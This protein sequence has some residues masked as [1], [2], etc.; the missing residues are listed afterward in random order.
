MI[1][2]TYF[3]H[4]TTSDNEQ[5]FSTGW[6]E[7]ELSEIGNRQVLELR[8]LT[9]HMN[10]D[11]V[12]CSDLGRAVDT[13]NIVFSAKNQIIQDC[14][15][16][17]ANYGDLNQKHKDEFNPDPYWYIHNYFPNGEK[18]K[19]VEIRIFDFLKSL[20]WEFDNKHVAIVAHKAPQL[21]LDVLL[22][23]RTWEQAIDDDWRK[24]GM[25]QPGWIYTF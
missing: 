24:E 20:K 2:I 21:A 6:G 9:R 14:R 19:D 25:W 1:K 8:N 16:R 15:L 5:H 11:K 4:G 23:N 7:S 3:V 10:F 13:A 18:Y 12:Y 17:E 22:K